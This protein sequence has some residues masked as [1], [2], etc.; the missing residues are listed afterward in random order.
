MIQ[1]FRNLNVFTKTLIIWDF[2]KILFLKGFGSFAVTFLFYLFEMSHRLH[3]F[4]FCLF[5]FFCRAEKHIAQM[6]YCVV[7]PLVINV[8]YLT[9]FCAAS[10]FCLS[11]SR[12]MW[13]QLKNTKS[14][15]KYKSAIDANKQLIGQQIS[16]LSVF[17]FFKFHPLAPYPPPT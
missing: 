12:A 10:R 17:F 3:V 4:D 7:F 8:A 1:I 15:K 5:L 14:F 13:S 16:F 2:N 6:N 11:K 9:C